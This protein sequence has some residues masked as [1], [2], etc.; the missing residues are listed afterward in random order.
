MAT[1]RNR[2]S[3]RACALALC[4]VWVG[5]T[6]AVAAVSTMPEVPIAKRACHDEK[7]VLLV[8]AQF[9]SVLVVRGKGLRAIVRAAWGLSDKEP[10]VASKL[11]IVMGTDG[12]VHLFAIHHGCVRWSLTGSS[13][14]LTPAFKNL[15]QA[16]P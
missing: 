1:H 8:A 15:L 6:G 16:Q 9:G 12:M 5:A 11:L 13:S 14:A 3:F 2:I 10:P 7:T 4:L